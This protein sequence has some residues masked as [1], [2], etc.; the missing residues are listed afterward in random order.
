MMHP[1]DPKPDHPVRKTG[2]RAPRPKDAATLILVRKVHGKPQV[3]MGQR[4]EGHIFM[5]NKF[6]FPGG[7]V[8]A[9]DSRVRPATP[10]RPDVE[11]KLHRHAKRP[12]VQA[13]ALAAVRETYEE[14]GLLIGNLVGDDKPPKTRSK[15]WQEFLSHGVVPALDGFEF[16]ARAIT[17]PHRHRRFDA[18]FFMADA[19][20]IHNDEN[21]LDESSGELLQLKWVG[22]DEAHTLDL[23]GITRA[24]LHEVEQR[25]APS[26]VAK[27]PLFVHYRNGKHTL[28]YL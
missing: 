2:E 10:L 12:N 27:G 19:E 22:L 4:A 24:V 18:R 20:L 15:E 28:D 14:T 5:P 8:H 1:F 17:P 16:I 7:R 25:C 9:S 3:L 11:E 6:V 21:K 13:L 23:P 26:A